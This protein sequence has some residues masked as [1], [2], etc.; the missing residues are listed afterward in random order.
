MTVSVC[1]YRGDSWN[2]ADWI[3]RW[4][5]RRPGQPFADVPSHLTLVVG[6]TLCEYV[7]TGY[8]ERQA[9]PA[10]FAWSVTVDVPDGAA[11]EAFL[12][13]QQGARYDW[14]TILLIAA[15]KFVPARCFKG[16]RNNKKHICS[17]FVKAALEAGG[18]D[19][20]RWLRAQD[21]PESPNDIHYA[22]RASF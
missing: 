2:I 5:T 20:P 1:F 18:W 19:C 15:N 6:E 17:W 8:Q 3:V 10:D 7:S 21:V 11:L 9:V 16:T 12:D 22:L 13:S 14:L 4:D